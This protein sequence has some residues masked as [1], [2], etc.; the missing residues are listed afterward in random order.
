VR[1][2]CVRRRAEVRIS[3]RTRPKLTRSSTS[4]RGKIAYVLSCMSLTVAAIVNSALYSYRGR[5]ERL[6]WARRREVPAGHLTGSRGVASYV[7]A[8]SPFRSA[9]RPR[10]SS[11][12]RH[13]NNSCDPRPPAPMWPQ[14]RPSPNYILAVYAASTT[15]GLQR[16][17]VARPRENAQH[18][19][20]EY[21]I[22]AHIYAQ[23]GI[24]THAFSTLPAIAV[25]PFPSFLVGNQIAEYSLLSRP[26][27]SAPSE[28]RSAS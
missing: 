6:F 8:G 3:C 26:T 20:S 23:S 12:E 28:R 21:L 13:R 14:P 19:R 11:K 24:L 25:E 10:R 18:C 5:A 27:G 9:P 4:L 17:L 22:G 15:P 7:I 16:T 2:G 1:A